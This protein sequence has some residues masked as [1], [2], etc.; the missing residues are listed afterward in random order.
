MSLN[1]CLNRA[2]IHTLNE[3]R[4]CEHHLASCPH[5]DQLAQQAEK[6]KKEEKKKEKERK[7]IKTSQHNRLRK[8][9]R[10]QKERK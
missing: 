8:G 3:R 6:K 10:G 9:K 1:T 4:P 7:C 2:L 5:K